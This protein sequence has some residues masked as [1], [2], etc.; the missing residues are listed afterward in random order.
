MDRASFWGGWVG[1]EFEGFEKKSIKF[2]NNLIQ[3]AV[4]EDQNLEESPIRH[5][6]R[7]AYH[8]R[9]QR[10]IEPRSRDRLSPSAD[11]CMM[12]TIVE[13]KLDPEHGRRV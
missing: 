4:A 1:L 12:F 11:G 10:G 6:R 7:V 5:A 13:K 2:E 8:G 3:R 9:N